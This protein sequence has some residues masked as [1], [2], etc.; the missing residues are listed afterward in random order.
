MNKH[1]K[2][3]RTK[4]GLVNLIYCNQKSSSKRRG[5]SGPSYSKQELKEWLYSQ[6]FFHLLFDNWK[7]LDY[8]KGYSPSVD[9]LD[10]SLGYSF[11]NI[12]L[13]DWKT[14][15][16]KRALQ[17]RAGD[18]YDGPHPH[19]KVM[20]YS[21]DGDFLAEYISCAETSRVLG[22]ERRGITYAC[23]KS[24]SHKYYGFIFKYKEF[25]NG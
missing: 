14:N 3:R 8:Q 5:H 25:K 15:N 23:G 4:K 18:V 22:L 6:E 16:K 19:K 17:V 12:Q 1:A 13:T 2:Y 11:S 10:D 24:I 20:Q 21:Q 7:R 9:R